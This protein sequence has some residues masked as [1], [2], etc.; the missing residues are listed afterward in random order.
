VAFE[1]RAP[2]NRVPLALRYFTLIMEESDLTSRANMWQLPRFLL[3]KKDK[4]GPETRNFSKV[5]KFQYENN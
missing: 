3:A 2:F 4:K 5:Q 1:R